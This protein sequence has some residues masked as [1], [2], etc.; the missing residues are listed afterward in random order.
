MFRAL[1][2]WFD[3]VHISHSFLFL[4]IQT[5]LRN[6][7][8]PLPRLLYVALWPVLA[9]LVSEGTKRRDRLPRIARKLSS[10]T[11]V[12]KHDDSRRI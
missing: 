9:V 4:P 6:V 5:W 7:A 8:G 12:S 11:I 1:N 3:E 2:G 10:L